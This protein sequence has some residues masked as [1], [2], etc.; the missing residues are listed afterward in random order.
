MNLTAGAFPVNAVPTWEWQAVQP[1][2]GTCVLRKYILGCC[3]SRRCLEGLGN[4][5]K[6]AL[7]LL[8]S[9][10]KISLVSPPR[11]RRELIEEQIR[12]V[13]VDTESPIPMLLITGRQARVRAM[14]DL[15]NAFNSNAAT[16]ENSFLEDNFAP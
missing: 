7:P 15:Y 11:L 13:E 16:Q 4:R 1:T 5:P 6:H 9:S 12:Y 8:G 3:L 2:N 10:L 14:V